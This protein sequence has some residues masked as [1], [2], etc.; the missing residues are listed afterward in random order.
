LV[1]GLTLDELNSLHAS[2]I[3]HWKTHQ[4]AKQALLQE[5]ADG[6]TLAA[7]EIKKRHVI[8]EKHLSDRSSEIFEI[9]SFAILHVYFASLGFSLRRFSTT[10]AN[11][12]GMDFICGEGIYQVTTAPSRL[13]IERDLAKLPGTKRVIVAPALSDLTLGYAYTNENLLEVVEDQDLSKHFLA[14]LLKKDQTRNTAHHLQRV[15]EVAIAEL[16]RD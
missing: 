16:K 6:L 2:I 8:I 11:D 4:S 7:E 12:G 5:F 9:M 10:F 1:A 15:L 3:E 14:W 13:K